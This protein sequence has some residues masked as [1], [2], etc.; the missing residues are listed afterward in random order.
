[1]A[2]RNV[3][4]RI[5]PLLLLV[6]AVL[7]LGWA[8]TGLFLLVDPLALY[9]WGARA[10]LA[11]RQ[12]S[13]DGTPYM[14]DVVTKNPDIDTLFVGGSTGHQ[15][16]DRMMEA[17]WPRSGRAFNL[18]HTS[19]R[20]ADR[21]LIQDKI[22]EFS[23]ARRVIEEIDWRYQLPRAVERRVDVTGNDFPLFLYDNTM[24]NDVRGV[25]LKTVRLS[26]NVAAGGPVWISDWSDRHWQQQDRRDYVRFLS[27]QSLAT[28]KAEIARHRHD[29]DTPSTLDCGRLDIIS[30]DLV[31]FARALSHRGIELDVIFPV[32]SPALFYEWIDRDDRLRVNGKSFL[33]DHLVMRRCVVEA[34]DG[35]PR[36]RIFGF[37]DVAGLATN[38]ANFRDPG[39]LYNAGAARYMLESIARGTHRLTRANIGQELD[40]MHASIVNY[41]VVDGPPWQASK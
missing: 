32:Y 28:L 16:T 15:F 14:V 29:V 27:P 22:L 31:P 17:T 36:V 18:S 9:P 4:R 30:Q 10:R 5:R 7:V 37:D 41:Q 19:P 2:G 34:L 33:D 40:K 39:H 11:D 13:M 38:V 21:E 6:A 8:A 25:G 26:A 12:Y 35:I 20:P 23:H 1:M 3:H 24:W